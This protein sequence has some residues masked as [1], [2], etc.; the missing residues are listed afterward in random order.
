M[1]GRATLVTLVSTICITVTSM[2]ENV[3]AHL[4]ALD[5]SVGAGGA[6]NAGGS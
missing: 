3:I 4:R 6:I 1:C 5:S 2:T